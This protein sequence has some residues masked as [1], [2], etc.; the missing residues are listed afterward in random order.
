[1]GRNLFWLRA[2]SQPFISWGQ[3]K[4]SNDN[5]IRKV[6]VNVEALTYDRL[7]RCVPHGFRNEL[8]K[9]LIEELIQTLEEHPTIRTRILQGIL[10]KKLTL[11]SVSPTLGGRSRDGS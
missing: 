2:N 4:V 9:I 7:A 8:L 11:A 5:W 1:M 10:D 3:Q 6:T